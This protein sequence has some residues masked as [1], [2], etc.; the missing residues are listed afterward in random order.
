M[1]ELVHSDGSGYQVG[2][3][4]EVNPLAEMFTLNMETVVVYRAI[5]L[6]QNVNIQ[7][8][9]YIKPKFVRYINVKSNFWRTSNV[10]R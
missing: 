8:F 4:I 3:N 5:Y 9:N 2:L 6:L 7:T 10:I 1:T